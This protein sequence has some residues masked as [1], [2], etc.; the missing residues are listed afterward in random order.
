MVMNIKTKVSSIKINYINHINTKHVNSSKMFTKYTNTIVIIY[1]ENYIF[2]LHIFFLIKQTKKRTT[3]F[4]Y[5]NEIE[6][7]LCGCVCLKWKMW[8]KIYTFYMILLNVEKGKTK[9]KPHVALLIFNK[10]FPLEKLLST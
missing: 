3:I 2:F 7:Q 9:K 10:N 5:S 4:N 1:L 6:I 8:N